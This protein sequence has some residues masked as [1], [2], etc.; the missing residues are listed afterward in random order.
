VFVEWARSQ[1][2]K[3]D[4]VKGDAIIAGK[5]S[6]QL[7]AAILESLEKMGAA[8]GGV[9]LNESIAFGFPKPPP[10]SP[11]MSIA[12]LFPEDG[13]IRRRAVVAATDKERTMT[14]GNMGYNIGCYRTELQRLGYLRPQSFGL[15][16]SWWGSPP[17]Y[18]I[19]HEAKR[20]MEDEYAAWH[21]QHGDSLGKHRCVMQPATPSPALGA[22]PAGSIMAVASQMYRESVGDFTSFAEMGFVQ[23]L[24]A[25]VPSFSHPWMDVQGVMV[26]LDRTER[27][28]WPQIQ[29]KMD[30]FQEVVPAVVSEPISQS[31]STQLVTSGLQWPEAWETYLAAMN[32]F[33]KSALD[34]LQSVAAAAPSAGSDDVVILVEATHVLLQDAIAVQAKTLDGVGTQSAGTVWRVGAGVTRLKVGDKVV[35]K[36]ACGFGTYGVAPQ[37]SVA[38]M[39]PSTSPAMA[40]VAMSGSMVAPATF[41]IGDAAAAFR[42]VMSPT[43]QAPVVL[44]QQHPP[45]AKPVG[46]VNTDGTYLITGGYGGLGLQVAD[47]LFSQGVRFFVLV[48][49]RGPSEEVGVKLDKMEA[50]GA[51]VLRGQADSS[52]EMDLQRLLAELAAA[53]GFPPLAGVLHAAGVLDD[54][55]IGDMSWERFSKAMMPKVEGARLLDKLTAH[56]DLSHFIL[57]SSITSI[58]ASG[59][60][61]N[62]AAANAYLDGVAARR[63]SRGAAALAVNWGPWADVGMAAETTT[64]KWDAMGLGMIA[65]AD[66]IGALQTTLTW[67]SSQCV[68]C[69][70]KLD[71][72]LRKYPELATNSLFA[73]MA[74]SGVAKPAA[75]R[76][77][78]Q[79]KRTVAAGGFLA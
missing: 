41:D 69:Q 65:P 3:V 25:L 7:P 15:S 13:M 42:H 37:S 52:S 50:E 5:E 40:V 64:R 63:T 19:V 45:T 2:C 59:G 57:F 8:E 74:G 60:Q 35:G 77:T 27:E 4:W 49:R 44:T 31:E 75:K 39:P 6:T 56:M 68:A 30:K 36:C 55:V 9:S 54:G 17:N 76:A 21:A 26:R 62:Y 67:A 34:D 24:G 73:E 43:E 38:L 32:V 46:S 33:M 22:I 79:K 72:L 78:K 14:H 28:G 18:G 51:S 20:I 61:S 66:G 10:G 23:L 71:V 47:W 16:Y 53:P 11:D 48:G 1:G 58:T 70:F 12:D 29:A